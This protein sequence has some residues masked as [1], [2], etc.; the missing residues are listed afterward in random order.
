MKNDIGPPEVSCCD[1]PIAQ[2]VK[3][4]DPAATHNVQCIT[5]RIA[6]S[7]QVN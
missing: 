7:F 4:N 6:S 2:P 5:P 3:V 1:G